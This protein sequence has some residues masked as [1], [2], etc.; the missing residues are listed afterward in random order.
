SRSRVIFPPATKDLSATGVGAAAA[1]SVSEP[2]APWQP[3][4]PMTVTT[5][6]VSRSIDRTTTPPSRATVRVHELT[7]GQ[8]TTSSH[9]SCSQKTLEPE[10][11]KIEALAPA[12]QRQ[13]G[14][15]LADD[16]AELEAVS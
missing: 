13:V 9:V 6:R 14:H 2:G 4:K 10:Q 7:D 3:T 16:A 1:D 12:L 11:S 15:D 5:M 8:R